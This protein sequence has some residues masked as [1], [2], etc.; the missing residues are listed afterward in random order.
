MNKNYIATELCENRNMPK[1]CCRGK[2]FLK[3][4]LQKEEAGKNAPSS[5]KEDTN[6]QWFCEEQEV[7]NY[8][9]DTKN[10]FFS[11]YLLKPYSISLSS[12]FHPPALLA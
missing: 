9:I 11:H 3:K 4:Q 5:A 7:T 6:I 12:V 10:I 8:Y 1:S 2:C